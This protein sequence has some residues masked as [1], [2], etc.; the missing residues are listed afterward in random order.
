MNYNAWIEQ[1]KKKIEE[2]ADGSVFV[3]K[4]LYQGVEW[5][6]LKRGERNQL[7][8]L[9]KAEV[10]KKN[11]TNVIMIDSPKG[12]ATTYKKNKED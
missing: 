6:G 11:I 1:A 8:K 5:D 9:F 7:G 10:V 4:D 3:L 2:I 12:K